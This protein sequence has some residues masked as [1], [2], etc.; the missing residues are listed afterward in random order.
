MYF[1]YYT[2]Q[3]HKN[4]PSR[5]QRMHTKKKIQSRYTV[6]WHKI[7]SAYES[8]MKLLRAF[9]AGGKCIGASWSVSSRHCARWRFDITETNF[10]K[11]MILHGVCV[12]ELHSVHSWLMQ[13][14]EKN[15]SA[16]MGDV[17]RNNLIQTW[18][19]RIWQFNL[20]MS[21]ISNRSY[22]RICESLIGSSFKSEPSDKTIH[23]YFQEKPPPIEKNYSHIRLRRFPYKQ[24]NI[25]AFMDAGDLNARPNKSLAYETTETKWNK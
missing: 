7:K 10:G 1:I 12:W 2:I 14:S 6:S 8:F 11:C 21:Y 24:R 23:Y 19:E 4:A 3:T 9:V 22:F 17:N 15:H 16:K 13:V 18:S 5:I 20:F 25:Y